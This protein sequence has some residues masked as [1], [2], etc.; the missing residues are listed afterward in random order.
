[1][2]DYSTKDLNK[3]IVDEMK[4]LETPSTETKFPLVQIKDGIIY[5]DDNT[6]E[7][8][9]SFPGKDTSIMEDDAKEEYAEET[10]HILSG[11]TGETFAILWIPEKINSEA[12]LNLCRRRLDEMQKKYY[13]TKTSSA[14][15]RPL[16][17]RIQMLQ[18]HVLP[19][20]QNQAV[21]NKSIQGNTYLWIKYVTRTEQEIKNDIHALTKRIDNVT[22]RQS[23]W[24]KSKETILN[25]IENWVSNTNPIQNRKYGP[26]I[27]APDYMKYS[28]RKK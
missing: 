8:V 3:K 11:V 27:I 26:T 20:I 24:I 2:F 9:L 10:S 16:Q 15:K 28:K 5:V 22:G 23:E 21:S 19:K 25:L 13:N 7:V 4:N 14:L 1:M 12:N 18:D 6:K 17:K